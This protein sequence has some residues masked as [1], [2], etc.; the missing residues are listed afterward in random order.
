MHLTEMLAS[1][2]IW[3]PRSNPTIN[4]CLLNTKQVSVSHFYYYHH[5]QVISFLIQMNVLPPVSILAHFPCR[6]QIFFLKT[7]RSCYFLALEILQE[8]FQMLVGKKCKFLFMAHKTPDNL[9]SVNHSKPLPL[10]PYLCFSHNDLLTRLRGFVL[11]DSS[12]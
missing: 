11:A 9:A 4:S 5:I 6:N 3:I 7:N 10:L 12:T 8:G 2:I 1:I